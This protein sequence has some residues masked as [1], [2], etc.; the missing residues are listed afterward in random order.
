M[1]IL[2]ENL[3]DEISE[4][5]EIFVTYFCVGTL[6]C[7]RVVQEAKAHQGCSV[8]DAAAAA[9]AAAAAGASLLLSSKLLKVMPVLGSDATWVVTILHHE[10]DDS[11]YGTK[12][13]TKQQ[14]VL[15]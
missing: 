14:Q 12:S 1:F 6:R 11:G 9:A 5:S 8:S 15:Q 4:D 13:T 7:V 10:R 2:F 3:S